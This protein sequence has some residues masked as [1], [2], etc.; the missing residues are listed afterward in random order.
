VV[1]KLSFSRPKVTG[2]KGIHVMAPLKEK[3]THD[4]AHAYAPRILHW[5]RAMYLAGR[6][7]ADIAR[8]MRYCWVGCNR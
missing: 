6:L 4:E 7:Q 1:S 2:G 8:L 5:R 3:I